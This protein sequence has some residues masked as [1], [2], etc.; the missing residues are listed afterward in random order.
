MEYCKIRDE[1]MKGKMM[2]EYIETEINEELFLN[3]L[4]DL[5]DSDDGDDGDDIKED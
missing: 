5:E 1:I 2:V 4:D 3:S